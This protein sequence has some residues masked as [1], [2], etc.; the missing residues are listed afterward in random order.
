MNDICCSR[1][2]LKFQIRITKEWKKFTLLSN[3]V[4][5]LFWNFVCSTTPTTTDS[6]VFNSI[7]SVIWVFECA[8]VCVCVCENMLYTTGYT[9]SVETIIY[10]N[11]FIY[12][13]LC[14]NTNRCTHKINTIWFFITFFSFFF[15]FSFHA[16]NMPFDYDRMCVCVSVNRVYTQ[17]YWQAAHCSC[18][19]TQLKWNG[20]SIYYALLW[21]YIVC[22]V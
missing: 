20:W 8:Y 15:F 3:A 2:V 6:L 10:T 18:S 1:I 4:Q 12:L 13:S 22:S 5:F 17:I 19:R 16:H 14:T 21:N 7:Q 9:F 11:I